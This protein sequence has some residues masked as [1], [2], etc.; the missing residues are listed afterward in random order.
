MVKAGTLPNSSLHLE[1]FRQLV[2]KG[3]PAAHVLEGALDEEHYLL[4]DS[5]L[6]Q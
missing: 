2:S 1:T 5:V 3:N 6:S 4:G